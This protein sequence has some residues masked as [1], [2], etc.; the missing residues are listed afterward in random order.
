[1]LRDAGHD[2][3]W[4]GVWAEGPGDEGIRATALADGR[5]LVTLDKDFG[6]LAIL[7][8]PLRTRVLFGSWASPP[9]IR[10]P[11]ARSWPTS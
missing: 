4:A 3:G 1:M 10:R 9:A 6:E 2:A 8:A 5:I 7:Y 11:L